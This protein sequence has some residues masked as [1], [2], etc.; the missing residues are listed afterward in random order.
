MIPPELYKHT[1]TGKFYVTTK[2][3]QVKDP[4]T[5]EWVEGIA[6]E[7]ADE[8]DP[9]FHV[10]TVED[11]ESHFEKAQYKCQV[12]L[13]AIL[14]G[15][16]GKEYAAPLRAITHV[17]AIQRLRRAAL[18]LVGRSLGATVPNPLR[19]PTCRCCFM[20]GEEGQEFCANGDKGQCHVSLEPE[21][22]D[23][24]DIVA[25]AKRRNRYQQEVV[26]WTTSPERTSFRRDLHA[27]SWGKYKQANGDLELALMALGDDR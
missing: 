10:R 19:C 26:D 8:D 15:P 13:Y 17:W 6:Y 21:P 2:E 27:P 11:F 22:V 7:P 24:T 23:P 4:T 1:D 3:C 5:R 18:V 9:R 12:D 25:L 20:I 16:L 14:H